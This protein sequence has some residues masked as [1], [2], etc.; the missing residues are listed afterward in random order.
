MLPPC[1]TQDG[2]SPNR[3]VTRSASARGAA[4]STIRARR[5]MSF[6]RRRPLTRA[7]RQRGNALATRRRLGHT[8][9]SAP[10]LPC[11]ERVMICNLPRPPRLSGGNE[12]AMIWAPLGHTV[13]S[14][15]HVFTREFI[16][17]FSFF[18]LYP[19]PPV[20]V[21]VEDV[22]VASDPANLPHPRSIQSKGAQGRHIASRYFW[23]MHNAHIL[24]YHRPRCLRRRKDRLACGDGPHAVTGPSELVRRQSIWR[25]YRT[26]ALL[27]LS[28]SAT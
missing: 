12:R 28:G 21:A 5:K 9:I 13:P 11:S 15:T 27:R 25:A 24:P 19:R 22:E 16:V 17:L 18:S 2:P 14:L 6:N 3:F 4:T 7:V 8:V 26:A 10:N 23:R 1:T 20:P